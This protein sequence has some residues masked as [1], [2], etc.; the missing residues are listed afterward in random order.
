MY[1]FVWDFRNDSNSVLH[2][3]R[4]AS[5]KEGY[6]VAHSSWFKRTDEGDRREVSNLTAH[7]SAERELH[8]ST[9]S[10]CTAFACQKCNG[11]MVSHRSSNCS[12][13][14]P[15]EA[16]GQHNWQHQHSRANYLFLFVFKKIIKKTIPLAPK[17]IHVSRSF[18]KSQG[19]KKQ[20]EETGCS[21]T[22][23]IM[24]HRLKNCK[25]RR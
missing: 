4:A 20:A 5:E 22:A 13:V 16:E 2:H 10:Y 23:L 17:H 11:I 6:S 15:Y 12:T 19:G 21:F 7:S 3:F 1:F 9:G 14:R 25:P 18:T 24:K 8:L